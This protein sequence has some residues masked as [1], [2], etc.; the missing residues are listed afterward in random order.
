MKTKVPDRSDANQTDPVSEKE[1]IRLTRTDSPN[2]PDRSGE[3]N[4]C[5]I[6]QPIL[7]GFDPLFKPRSAVGFLKT[8]TRFSEHINPKVFTY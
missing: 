5:Q 8:Y 4:H 6:V 2:R 1:P 3:D 7:K